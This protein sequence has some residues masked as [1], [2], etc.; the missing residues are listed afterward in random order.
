MLVLLAT[1]TSRWV[2]MGFIAEIKH[3]M[4]GSCFTWTLATALGITEEAVIKAAKEIPECQFRAYYSSE[5]ISQLLTRMDVEFKIRRPDTYNRWCRLLDRELDAGNKCIVLY[6]ADHGRILT[7]KRPTAQ[8]GHFLEVL[9]TEAF[10]F[11]GRQS[12]VDGEK[13]KEVVHKSLSDLYTSSHMFDNFVMDYGK[14][15]KCRIEIPKHEVGKGSRCGK[16]VCPITGSSRCRFEC[17][18]GGAVLV[19]KGR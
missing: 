15:R 7:K 11:S 2:N 8:S 6:N 4:T 5:L 16:S 19:L 14:L 9:E 3:C 17:D 13:N 12:N 1:Q 18:M 10:S